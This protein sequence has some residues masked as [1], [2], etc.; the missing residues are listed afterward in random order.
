MNIQSS[1]RLLGVIMACST[2]ACAVL[3]LAEEVEAKKD[4]L[5][6]FE[7]YKQTLSRSFIVPR[8]SYSGGG[9]VTLDPGTD[10][11][12][13]LMISSGCVIEEVKFVV[14]R[15]TRLKVAG[16]LLRKCYISLDPGAEVDIE[17]SSLED[18]EF[19]SSGS[20]SNELQPVLR[21]ENCLV[22]RGS[23]LSSANLLGLRMQD[24]LIRDQMK[25]G[26]TMRMTVEPPAIPHNAFAK[27]PVI[28]HTTFENC[29]IHD[30]ILLAGT[31]NSFY[32]NSGLYFDRTSL[33]KKVDAAA[34]AKL[35]I[36]WDQSNDPAELPA[37]GGGVSLVHLTHPI[38]PGYSLAAEVTEGKVVMKGLA[39]SAV[40]P[41]KNTL[42]LL[43]DD[44]VEMASMAAQAP[45]QEVGLELK[46]DQ[47]HVNGLL[48]MQLASGKEA[49]QIS[50][51]NITPVPG[52]ASVRFNQVA[53]ESMTTALKEVIKF[54]RLRH[55]G[56]TPGRDLEIAFEEKYSG[57]DGPSAAVAC[58]LL[59]ESLATGKTWDPAFA[60]TGD[61]NADGAVQPIGGVAAKIRGATK[62]ACKI[63][64]VPVKNEKA[65]QDIL[66]MDGPAALGAIH[67][68]ALEKFD[69]AVALADQKREGALLQAVSE[70]EAMRAVLIRDPRQAGAI[71][72]TPQAATRLQ[73]I[74]EKAP[75][76]LSAKY[77][78]LYA[79]G[80]MPSNLSLAGSLDAVDSN[81]T[82]LLQ[83]ITNDFGGKDVSS[84]K[85]DELGGA[86][87]QL[88]NLRPRLDSR[89]W[90][91]V[92][93]LVTF[94]EIVRAEVLNPSRSASKYNEMVARAKQAGNGVNAAKGSLLSNPT[95]VEEL[96]L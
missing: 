71:L 24:C 93:S 90:P 3:S 55:G 37:V 6:G 15:N 52:N 21:I 41:L 36:Y 88:R 96:G 78:L 2:L 33:F 17:S 31:N 10:H 68:F 51:M 27:H 91:Y 46:L 49:G 85:V 74:L 63:V 23:W 26:G 64:G 56:L 65:V 44:G 22:L 45:P 81:A 58:A 54:V 38:S 34:E 67:V 75:H 60:V 20:L 62:G 12:R 42:P 40:E 87:S 59:V 53:G 28:R 69:Q 66:I 32:R 9:T 72:R 5:P 83:A 50:R 29:L 57:K 76:S 73:S 30:T 16:A 39:I 80:R 14:R 43:G 25:S 95:V 7:A 79:Q 92:D 77:L 1:R 89:V 8:G 18:C 4:D 94:G 84:L 19:S 47:A 86:V 82:G 11:A 35:L 70:F 13:S 61:M 48:I